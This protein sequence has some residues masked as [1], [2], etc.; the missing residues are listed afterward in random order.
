MRYTAPYKTAAL[1]NSSTCALVC[2]N[3]EWNVQ[4][5]VHMLCIE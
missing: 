4:L 1:P 2:N 5:C 3:A